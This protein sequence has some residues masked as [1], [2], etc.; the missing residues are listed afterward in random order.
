VER[1]VMSTRRPGPHW[2][3]IVIG[4]AV[5]TRL[6][7]ALY[8]GD[9]VEA[10]PGA[11]DQITYDALAR[12]ILAGRGYS[13]EENWYPFTPAHTPT[14][15]W[16]FLYPLY[17]TGVYAVFGPHPLI[18][19]LIQGVLSGALAA[20]LQYTLGRRL[21]DRRVGLVTAAL[22]AGY[23]YFIFFD[24]ILTTESFYML[25]VLAILHLTLAASRAVS[26]TTPQ[27]AGESTR[28]ASLFIRHPT[29]WVALGA[30]VGV[31]T[32]LR[33]SILPWVPVMLAW[34]LWMG[35]GHVRWHHLLIPVIILALFIAPWSIRNLA[36]YD[37][38]LPL[39]SNA[40][41]ALYAANHPNLGTRWIDAYVPPKPLQ[42]AG[43]NE[44]EMNSVLTRLGIQFILEEPGR[45]LL[46]SLNRIPGFF[47]FWPS[48]NSHILS[49]IS[50]VF[51]YGVYLPFFLYGLF[52]SRKQW[53]RCSLIYSFAVVYCLMHILTY[54]M[55][56]YRLP[57]DGALMPFAALAVVDL[58][59]RVRLR[60]PRTASNRQLAE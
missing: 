31:T 18:A 43:M 10:L 13:F 14:A 45:V 34:T 54:T 23:I 33:Q 41:W 29:V 19:R 59:Q 12:S 58:S 7:A 52:L 50:R 32:L 20:W 44:A 26:A 6:G 25:G 16:S 40:G 17:L 56:R 46:L 15:H 60:R 39:N 9:R 53:R 30:V 27:T 55:I 47:K 2:V 1:E 24:A 49:N 51:S 37:T 57:V 42:I 28:H 11:Y 8:A 5:V 21:F 36:A 38:F 3:W 48:P 22:S 35:Q 4:F